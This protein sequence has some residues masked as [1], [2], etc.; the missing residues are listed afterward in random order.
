MFRRGNPFVRAREETSSTRGPSHLRAG[1]S[2]SWPS[3]SHSQPNLLKSCQCVEIYIKRKSITSEYI[4]QG[5]VELKQCEVRMVGCTHTSAIFLSAPGISLR[6]T[7]QEQ[8][9]RVKGFFMNWPLF[10]MSS[11]L[12][13]LYIIG[14]CSLTQSGTCQVKSRNC[15]NS[16]ISAS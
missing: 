13:S 9:L 5:G 10:S 8:Q 12:H 6:D 16:S 14:M 7:Q 3:H 11:N 15:F 1:L 2:L 4:L